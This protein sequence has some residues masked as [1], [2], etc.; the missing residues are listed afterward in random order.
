MTFK[1]EGD[2]IVSVNG[3][4]TASCE[5]G[6]EYSGSIK[7]GGGGGGGNFFKN[8]P[9]KTQIHIVSKF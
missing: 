1:E 8:F 5:Y 9:R 7:S 6:N 2:S 3:S 4:V